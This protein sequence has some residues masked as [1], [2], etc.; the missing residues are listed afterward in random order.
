MPR[1]GCEASARLRPTSTPTRTY[2]SGD[3]SGDTLSYLTQPDVK[4]FMGRS[5][6]EMIK[7]AEV[8]FGEDHLE[9]AY[10]LYMKYITLHIEKLPR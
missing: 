1:R 7:M 6:N 5:G 4:L 10:V 2:L 9:A 3:I 8:Y